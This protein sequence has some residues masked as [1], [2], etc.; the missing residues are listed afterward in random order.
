V[1]HPA[2]RG[3]DVVR[4]RQRLRRVVVTFLVALLCGGIVSAM[5]TSEGT[6]ALADQEVDQTDA[7][8][9]PGGTPDLLSCTEHVDLPSLDQ[10]IESQ[11]SP[12]GSHLAFT[13]IVTSPSA[14]TV[15]GFEEDPAL[16]VLDMGTRTVTRLGAGQHPR[17]SATGT[18]LSFWR[19]GQLEVV[20]AGRLAA[21]IEATI[22]ETRWVGDQLVYWDGDEIHG[23]TEAADVVISQVS[24]D[25]VPLYPRDWSDFSADGALFSLTRY[26]MDGSAARWVGVVKTGQLTPLDTAGTTYTEWSPAGETLLVRSADTV[27]LRGP[28]GFDAIAPLGAFPGTVHGWTPDGTALLMG[29]VAPTV[30]AGPSFDRFAVWDGVKITAI[31]TLPNLL[32]SRTFSPDGRYF[33]GVSRNGLYETDLEVYRCGTRPTTVP[34]R[35]DPVARARQ[36]RIDGDPRRFVRPVMGYFSQFLQGSHTG[37]DVAAPYGSLITA[38]DDGVVDWVGWRP[39]GGRAVCVQHAGGLESCDYH[40]SAA[41]VQVGQHV[42]RGEPVALIG[43]TGATTG[44]HV[45]WETKLN[46]LIVDPLKQ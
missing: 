25:F 46:G 31:A 12:D 13:R 4:G 34:S 18:Y 19:K 42:A 45:H 9:G 2:S 16:S 43:M 20:T 30:P 10:A 24:P 38:A 35:A 39:V 28:N 33:A 26:S 32:G 11:W 36:G 1:R 15:T 41:L 22:P 5:R 6:V 21:T 14:V 7:I 27:E 37:I 23:W 17:W 40:T 3:Y 29:K 44:P 8:G